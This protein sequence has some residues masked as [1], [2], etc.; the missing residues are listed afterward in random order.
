MLLQ[1]ITTRNLISDVSFNYTCPY[2]PCY[3]TSCMLYNQLHPPYR[4]KWLPLL[5]SAISI[6]KR[7]QF[8]MQMH[9]KMQP[10]DGTRPD[11]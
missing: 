6:G 7:E 9:V 2:E 11:Q 3:F 4:L 10:P 1:Q 8:K 5:E